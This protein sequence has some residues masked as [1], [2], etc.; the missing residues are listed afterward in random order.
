MSEESTTPDPVDLMRQ[1]ADAASR[2]DVDATLSFF[3]P[4]AVLDASVTGLGTFEGSEAISGFLEDWQASYED[5]VVEVAEILDL[6]TAS[7]LPP[8]GRAVA[9]LAA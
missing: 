4:N 3:A 8:T 5:Y 2:G 1:F 7:C 6:G 9:R